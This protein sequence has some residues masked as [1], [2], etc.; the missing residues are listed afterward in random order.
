MIF[1]ELTI[2]CAA[3]LSLIFL[4]I[5]QIAVQFEEYFFYKANGWDFS[6]DS[7]KDK[8]QVDKKIQIYDLSLNNW[9]RFY[10]FRPAF[11]SCVTLFLTF[12]TWS[13]FQ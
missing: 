2:V 3:L 11:L 9:Q 4:L 1:L 5:N 10:I 12:T 6:V 8:I 7:G 13:L